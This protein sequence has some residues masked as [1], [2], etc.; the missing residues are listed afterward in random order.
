MSLKQ[1]IVSAVGWSVAIRMSVQ[2][3]TWAMTLVVIRILSP[4][5]YGLMAVSQIFVNFMLGFGSLGFGDAL[6]QQDE[7]PMTVVARLFGVLLVGAVTLGTLMAL[8]AYPIGAW[9]HDP[10]LVPLIQVS[11]LGF[12]FTALTALPRAYLT[13]HLRVRP[14]FIMELASG[15]A[16]AATVIVLAIGGYGVWS[17]MLGWLA[18]NV[19]KVL[20]F[21]LLAS[22]Y[23]VWPR[24][25]FA[26]IGPLF[27]FGIYRTFEYIVWMI[28]ASA[29]ILIISRWLGPVE[30]GVYV[31]AANFAA[32]PVNKI[33]PIVNATAF[34]AF[35]LI[36]ERPS[37]A[38]FYALKAVRM[39]A[40]IAVPLFFGLSVTAPEVVDLVFG[41]NWVAA[42]PVLGV[43]ALA[44]TF[45]AILLVVPNFLQG[46]GDSRASFWCTAIGA[47]IF[48]PAFVIGC[49]WGIVGVAWAWLIGYPIMY[50]ATAMIASRRGGL[51]TRLLMLAPVQ[52]IVAGVI[53]MGAVMAIR[54]LL[55]QTL[56]EIVGF[57]VLVAAGAATYGG[58]LLVL[59]RGLAMEMLQVFRRA[60][61]PA[62]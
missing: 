34:P 41:P 11:S 17:L 24:L 40:A 25:G 57:A 55:P 5:D 52:P 3:V 39:M 8:A 31:V 30:L 16:G 53:M 28:F 48:P 33:A 54:N 19:V 23:Y 51:D 4:N 62:G 36:Q 26:G 60:P 61:S 32:M 46:I 49:H 47:V 37:E 27:S 45:R 7:T 1:T 56:P 10:R 12:L 22:E 15:L 44:I 35:A 2:I 50:A 20:G 13:K 43:L 14:M 42:R 9:Y 18:T 21:V 29:D 59:F 38:R 6:V 58:V